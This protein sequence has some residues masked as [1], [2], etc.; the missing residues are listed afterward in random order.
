MNLTILWLAPEFFFTDWLPWSISEHNK[1][2]ALR[3]KLGKEGG[4]WLHLQ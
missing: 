2:K 4:Y 3:G 1:L